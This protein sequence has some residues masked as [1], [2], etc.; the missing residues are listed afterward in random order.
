MPSENI[1]FLSTPFKRMVGNSDDGAEGNGSEMKGRVHSVYC[2]LGR[3]ILNRMSYF[4]DQIKI[5]R[6]KDAG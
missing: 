1:W 6:V 5:S 3:S 4:A 2:Y